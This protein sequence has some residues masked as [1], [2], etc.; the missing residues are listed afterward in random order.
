MPQFR[1]ETLEAKPNL[2]AVRTLKDVIEIQRKCRFEKKKR[3][4]IDLLDLIFSR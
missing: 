3:I 2:D 4:E 1:K